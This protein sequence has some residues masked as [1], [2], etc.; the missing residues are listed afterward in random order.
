M[1]LN[2]C[3][4]LEKKWHFKLLHLVLLGHTNDFSFWQLHPLFQR[5]HQ[6]IRMSSNT[7]RSF[8]Y[9]KNRPK[10]LTVQSLYGLLTVPPA[11][12]RFPERPKQLKQG[13]NMI[14]ILCSGLPCTSLF[15]SSL[16]FN[17][18]SPLNSHHATQVQENAV[19]SKVCNM[20]HACNMFPLNLTN[21]FPRLL[22]SF[23]LGNSIADVTPLTTQFL[24]TLIF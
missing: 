6:C 15:N 9:F 5:Q 24:A 10:I 21:D 20:F 14:N 17:N 3:V 16:M 1:F 7:L 23:S 12:Q 8:K 18:T 11:Q 19:Q 22:F 13:I 4:F 2:N